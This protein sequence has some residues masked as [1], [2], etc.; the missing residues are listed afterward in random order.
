[1]ALRFDALIRA[2]AFMRTERPPEIWEADT[3]DVR[4]IPLLG[5]MIAAGLVGGAPLD[6]LTFN[7]SN[8]VV[9]RADEPGEPAELGPPPGEFVAAT[10]RG[11]T[12]LGPDHVWLPGHPPPASLLLGRL[13]ERL[14]EA[15]ARFAY[16]RRMP[17][18]G[19]VTVFLG[20]APV[21]T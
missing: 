1:M 7:V 18:E 15:G 19:S 3:D 4:F 9:P 12:D 6:A 14:A 8:V 21:A 11:C 17:P 13:A 16:V 10:V 5:E 20:R 2:H